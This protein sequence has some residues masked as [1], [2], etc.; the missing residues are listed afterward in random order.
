M[1]EMTVPKMTGLE[2]GKESYLAQRAENLPHLKA[3]NKTD[4]ETR[5]ESDSEEEER[6]LTKAV[7]QVKA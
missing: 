1:K 4:V 5:T 6:P 2:E 3:G 7:L